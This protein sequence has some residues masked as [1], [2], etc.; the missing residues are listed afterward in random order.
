MQAVKAFHQ[1]GSIHLVAGMSFANA[2]EGK[3]LAGDKESMADM[4]VKGSWKDR[5]K[6]TGKHINIKRDTNALLFLV[7]EDS[8]R[9]VWTTTRSTPKIL[10]LRT[11]Y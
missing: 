7:N 6:A 5:V 1:S 2:T 11:R 8:Y 3:I 4:G 10:L 9:C